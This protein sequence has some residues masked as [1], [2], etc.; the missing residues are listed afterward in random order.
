M[1]MLAPIRVCIETPSAQS[2]W[3][4]PYRIFKKKSSE[5]EVLDLTETRRR[6]SSAMWEAMAPPRIRMRWELSDLIVAS[7][8]EWQ[9]FEAIT[10]QVAR[11]LRL[12]GS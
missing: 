10:S 2:R 7:V 8:Q 1:M 6:D 5:F 12:I 4:E 3:N 11:L 9:I